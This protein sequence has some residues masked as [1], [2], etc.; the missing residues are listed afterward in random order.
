MA[1]LFSALTKKGYKK[2]KKNVAQQRGDE[3]RLMLERNKE[4]LRV[5]CL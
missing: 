2:T 3:L 5:D 1:P 4:K